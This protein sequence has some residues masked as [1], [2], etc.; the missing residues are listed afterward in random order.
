MLSAVLNSTRAGPARLTATPHL[1]V[2]HAQ[3]LRWSMRR[4]TTVR[5][6]AC[7]ISCIFLPVEQNCC[8]V[9]VIRTASY[10][11]QLYSL[12]H[13]VPLSLLCCSI[14]LFFS[15]HC[16]FR[17]SAKLGPSSCFRFSI[18]FSASFFLTVS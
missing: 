3:T 7:V 16:C 17:I 6:R 9:C 1:R 10:T 18:R 12:C 11:R 4:A 5:V 2:R 13:L 14:S 15:S 8:C